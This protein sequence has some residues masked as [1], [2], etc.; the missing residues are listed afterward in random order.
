MRSLYAAGY[1]QA[2][3]GAFLGL[4]VKAVQGVFRRNG[5]TPRPA[6]K[7]DQR[8]PKNALWKGD[9]A[10]YKALHLRVYAERG[11]ASTCSVCGRSDTEATY[12]WANLTGNYADTKD[13]AAMCRKCHRAYDKARR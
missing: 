11:K 4:S 13:Y 3:V 6:I 7:R 5:I 1:T 8:G 2:E 10:G 12:D 9:Q